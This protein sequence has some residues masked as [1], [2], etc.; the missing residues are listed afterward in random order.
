[1]DLII[2]DIEM[3]LLTNKQ[4]ATTISIGKYYLVSISECWYRVRIEKTNGTNNSA[5]CFF[6]DVGD[7]EWFSYDNIYHCDDKFLKFPA[8]AV[9]FSLVGLEDFGENPDVKQHLDEHLAGKILIGEILTKSEEYIAQE[10][11]KELEAKIQIVLYD[12]SSDDDVQ[13]NSLILENIC[14]SSTPPKLE[15]IKCNEVY[16]SYISDN[17]DTYCHLKKSRSGLHYISKLIHQLTE[18]G[19]DYEQYRLSAT[20]TS[21]SSTTKNLY[22]IHDK[23]DNKWYRASI[24]SPTDHHHKDT[25]NDG[26]KTKLC[27]CVDYGMIKCVESNNIYRLDL[28]S[29]ALNKYP[30]QAILTKLNDIADFN[31]TV[32]ARLRGLLNPNSLVIAEVIGSSVIPVVNI[33]KRLEP[34]KILCKINDTIRMEQELEKYLYKENFTN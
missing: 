11:S 32:V 34:N 13:L 14:E 28:L 12:T 30:P 27:K 4:L 21:P 1:M 18:S 7:R 22:L 19:L 26:M 2:T 16:I 24:L 23:D 6:I 29:T 10:K 9:C 33:F 31:K 20:S 15:R 17:G 8:Q 3:S 5:L 25:V